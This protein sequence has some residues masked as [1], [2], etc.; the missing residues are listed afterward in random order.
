MRLLI[1]ALALGLAVAH[2]L[3]AQRQLR[4]QNVILVVSDGVRWQE[5]F[6]GADSGIIFGEPRAVGRD[7]IAL[8][9]RFWRPTAEARRAELFPFLW[10]VVAREGQIFGNRSSGST[11]HCSPA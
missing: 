8:R 5:V 3:S 7:S 2:D 11:V 1:C 6:S 10:G 4:S 9:R